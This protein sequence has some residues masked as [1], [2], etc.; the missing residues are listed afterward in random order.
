[1]SAPLLVI[2]ADDF[3]LT[4]G[5]CRGIVEA[6][7]RG[8]VSATSVLAVGRAFDYGA[9]LLRDAPS[10]A[11]GAHLAL[12]GE[13]PPLLSAREIPTLVDRRG[14]FPLSYRAVAARGALRRIDPD[15]VRREFAAQLDRI[16]AA[17]LRPQ[18]LDTHQHVHL[19]PS[20]GRVVADL[21]RESGIGAVRRPWS[22][23]HGPRGL[24]VRLLARRLSAR[25]AQ[26][27]IA[28][29]ALYAGLDEAGRLDGA[30]LDA[31]LRRAADRGVPSLEVNTHPGEEDADVSRFD[32]RYRWADELALM[33]A[34]ATARLIEARGF[35][36]GAMSMLPAAP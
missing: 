12:V 35:R 16:R 32:W 6:H 21:A 8:V 11:V 19:W 7:R 17:G 3:G 15:D 18:H 33:Q 14:R 30:G 25:L 28:T 27:G 20:V 36:L 34:P 13:D 22:A 31:A 29:T 2:T 10:L 9:A 5:V 26:C 4:Q 23:S 1:M 24:G